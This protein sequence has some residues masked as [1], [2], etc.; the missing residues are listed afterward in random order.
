MTSFLSPQWVSASRALWSQSLVA[1]GPDASVSFTLT[2]A[3]Q[4]AGG[5]WWRLE[6]GALADAGVGALEDAEVAFTL[7]YRDAVSLVK[8]ESDLNAG[9]MQG[10]IKV[11]GDT[12]KLFS[13]LAL[14]A[15]EAYKAML[16]ELGRQTDFA[17]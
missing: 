14:T 8:G 10:R 16:S 9:F 12:A 6:D 2:G 1:P 7:S 5:F 4:D 17:A 13:V 3:P 11:A 15:S